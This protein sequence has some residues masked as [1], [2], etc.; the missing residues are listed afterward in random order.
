[1]TEMIKDT[2]LDDW[3]QLH[4]YLLHIS[5]SQAEAE[6]GRTVPCM[7]VPHAFASTSVKGE[8]ALTHLFPYGCITF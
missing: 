4:L 1:M 5:S 3:W 2:T 6:A 8:T 7:Y